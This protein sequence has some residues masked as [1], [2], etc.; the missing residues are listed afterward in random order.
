MP[1][2]EKVR[3]QM[4]LCGWDYELNCLVSLFTKPFKGENEEFSVFYDLSYFNFVIV[5][6]PDGINTL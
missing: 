4:S 6:E 1:N 3:H 2:P 5:Q